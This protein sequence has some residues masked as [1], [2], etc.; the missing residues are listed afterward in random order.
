MPLVVN[1]LRAL[2]FFGSVLLSCV[3]L[4]N[5]SDENPESSPEKPSIA[6][7]VDQ[8]PPE[9]PPGLPLPLPT[10]PII[11]PKGGWLWFW[12]I[13][14][15]HLRNGTIG[16]DAIGHYGGASGAK[17]FLVLTTNGVFWADK[18]SNMFSQQETSFFRIVLPSITHEEVLEQ[19]P[20][21]EGLYSPQE[22]SA[23]FGTIRNLC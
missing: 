12:D 7:P 14:C 15:H 1:R 4:L 10:D 13:M 19:W 17:R 6:D 16:I 21:L 3:L 8:E 23:N 2:C 22:V 18:A 5:Q 9:L 11:V 20:K